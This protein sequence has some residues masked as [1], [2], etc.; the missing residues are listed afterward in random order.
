[1]ISALGRQGHR[2]AQQTATY[3]ALVRAGVWVNNL[4]AE[5]MRGD[6]DDL[7]IVNEA[8]RVARQAAG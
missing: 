7:V 1:V 5:V 8:L 2:S 3:R 4:A 6:Q